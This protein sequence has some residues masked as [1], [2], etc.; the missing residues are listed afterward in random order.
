MQT[1]SCVPFL[2]K[3]KN[4]MDSASLLEDKVKLVT[5]EEEFPSLGHISTQGQIPSLILIGHK[6]KHQW[7]AFLQYIFWEFEREES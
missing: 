7:S 5:G 6:L 2:Y 1:Y 3:H 4:F